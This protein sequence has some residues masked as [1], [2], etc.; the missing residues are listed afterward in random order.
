MGKNSKDN[1]AKSENPHPV[2]ADTARRY[3]GGNCPAEVSEVHGSK[4]A[5]RI[6]EDRRYASAS[7]ATLENSPGRADASIAGE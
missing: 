3:R 1:L 2:T 6:T 7:N 4:K 5:T